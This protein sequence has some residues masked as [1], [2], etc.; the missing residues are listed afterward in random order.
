MYNNIKICGEVWGRIVRFD[1][2]LGRAKE[3]TMKRQLS[4]GEYRTIDLALFAVMLALFEFLI[5]RFAAFSLYA[6][7]LAAVIT[8]I[9]YMRWGWWG[10]IHA[11]LAGLLFCF[12]YSGIAPPDWVRPEQYIIYPLGNLFS[13]AAVAVLKKVGEEQVR[14]SATASLLFSLSVI[15]LM[16][17]GRAVVG[18]V[19]MLLGQPG[20]PDWAVIGQRAL[21]CFTT[22]AL[23]ILFTL[24]VT[25]IV[26][27]LD[28][29]FEEQRHYLTRIQEERDLDRNN[30]EQ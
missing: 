6:V 14:Q 28:G 11:V 29:V 12:Y 25:W 18:V 26:R 2:T 4:L 1:Q 22:D 15:L 24:V 23:S 10:A 27:R 8:A 5:V 3:S 13:L 19:I 30:A 7:S 16:Q 9:V 21:G 20:Q 17:G